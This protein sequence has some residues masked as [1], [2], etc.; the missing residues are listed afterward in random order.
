MGANW[1]LIKST[2][3]WHYKKDRKLPLIPRYMVISGEI[4]WKG[5]H[6]WAICLPEQFC[7]SNMHSIGKFMKNAIHYH[8]KKNRTV[9][10]AC[11]NE[12]LEIFFL[13]RQNWPTSYCPPC[14]SIKLFISLVNPLL[15]HLLSIA[16]DI[17]MRQTICIHL[18]IT[19]KF[20]FWCHFVFIRQ[21]FIACRLPL[22]LWSS[23]CLFN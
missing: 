22:F 9:N 6:H 19:N 4:L 15:R 5:Y 18:K 10:Y 8:H 21:T 7:R 2:I 14:I 3:H 11:F 16:F 13:S 1:K 23:N 17:R 12:Y 20:I